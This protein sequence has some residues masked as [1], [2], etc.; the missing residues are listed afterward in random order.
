[1]PNEIVCKMRRKLPRIFFLL[2]VS[3]LSLNFFATGNGTGSLIIPQRITD[4]AFLQADSLWV[5]SVMN[6]MNLDEK[7][8]QMIMI[9]AYSNRDEEHTEE[10]S[11]IIRKYKVG[12]VIFFQ[13]G[14]K[15]QLE[16]TRRF[17]E[18]SELPLLIAI[19]GEWGLGMRLDSVISYP[20]QMELGAIRDNALIYRMGRDIARQMK[21]LG[22]NVNFAPVADVNNNPANPVINTRSFGE[23]RDNVALKTVAYM[24]GMQDEGLLVTAKHF[25]GHGDTDTDSHKAL[26]VIPHDMHRLD[27]IELFPFRY[28]ISEGLSG[29]MVA[30]LH[31]PAI[32]DREDRPTTLSASAIDSL[33]VGEMGF[34]GLIFTDAL[35]MKG[36]SNFM[37]PGKLEV[38]A[39][40]A[41]NDILLMPADVQLAIQSV[42]KEVRRGTISE[43]TINAHVRKILLA[44]YWANKHRLE[45]PA[46]KELDKALN[47]PVYEVLRRSLVENAL[48]LV[49]NRNKVLPLRHME[50]IQMATIAI[51]EHVDNTFN[52][53]S[54]LYLVSD[55]YALPAQPGSAAVDQLIDRSKRYNVIVINLFGLSTSASKGYGISD[56]ALRLIKA[57]DSAAVVIVNV[58][59]YPYT[60][61]RLGELPSVDAIMLNYVNDEL[62]QSLAAQALFGGIALSGRLPV[63]AGPFFREGQGL[64]TE[65]LRLE[66]TFP[67][68]AGMNADTLA[69]IDAVVAEAIRAKA[70]PGCQVLVARE[71]KIV[72]NRSYGY[73]TFNNREAVSNDDLYDIAS[74]TKIAATIPSLM[75]LR[76]EGLFDENLTL[77]AYLPWL[78]TTNKGALLITDVL[79]HQAGLVP[80][81]PFYQRTIEPLDSSQELLSTKFS[82]VYAYHLGQ[83]T[84]GNRN[85]RFKDGYYSKGYKPGFTIQVADGLYLRSDYQ[86]SILHAIAVSELRDPVY[87]YSD[88]GYYLFQQMI[89]NLTDTLLY[90]FV[91][92]N[93]YAPLGAGTLGYLPLGRFGSEKIVPTENDMFFRRQLLRGYVHDPGAAMM[94]GVCGHAGIFSSANDLAKM[95]Q[96]LLDYGT[97]GGERFIDSTTVAR[98]TSCYNCTNGNRRALGFDR[99]AP[100]ADT[101]PACNSA[102]SNSFG[103]SGFTGTLAWMDPDT[104]LLYIFLSNRIHPDQANTGITDLNVRTRIQQLLYNAIEE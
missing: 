102:S 69:K 83:K 58:F 74:I 41:G 59:G 54:D 10:L 46:A 30:H 66:Y 17:R 95:M 43:E 23:N 11:R 9:P 27:S 90:P 63:T 84:Y 91:Y 37:E 80:W 25:P 33:L 4:P 28:A 29:I 64:T 35:N 99:P 2:L 16:M 26:P 52:K 89:E 38:E 32:D 13:G 98:F 79:T 97:Y 1:M 68:D 104:G 40:K 45:L 14:P 56:E 36:A 60:L 48:T 77:G 15:R 96:M 44:K 103:H 71:G 12:G 8:A 67:E 86:D 34:R 72:W 42:R 57:Q 87:R 78:D 21:Q 61:E 51:G 7:I 62:R 3:F 85:V 50:N 53:I 39:V 88:L 93:F 101:G 19:D 6:R 81:I 92:Y 18:E 100:E 75:R 55:H 5:D 76:D 82:T 94:G 65:K 24:K 31:V 70:L 73:K 49:R 22:I 20:R 47:S